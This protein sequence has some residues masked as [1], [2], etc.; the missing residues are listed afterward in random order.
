MIDLQKTAIFDR[1]TLMRSSSNVKSAWNKQLQVINVDLLSAFLL[2]ELIRQLVFLPQYL[3]VPV[4]TG[5]FT[6]VPHS[7]YSHVFQLLQ[8]CLPQYL[9]SCVPIVS[10]IDTY[11]CITNNATLFTY[12]FYRFRYQSVKTQITSL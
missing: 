10:I 9:L 4:V 6:T 2:F 12:S 11:I 3:C 7:T 8:V 5:V 1:G